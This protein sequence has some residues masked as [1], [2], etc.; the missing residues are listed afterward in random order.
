ML[1]RKGLGLGSESREQ[2]AGREQRAGEQEEARPR[3]GQRSKMSSC[4]ATEG[5]AYPS[6]SSPNAAVDATKPSPSP[7]LCV[8]ES[9]A[10]ML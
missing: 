8:L 1:R 5:L 10:W 9:C 7:A 6:A 2:G 3:K 4:S